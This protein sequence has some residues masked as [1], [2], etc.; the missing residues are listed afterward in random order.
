MNISEYSSMK[1]LDSLFFANIDA[2]PHFGFDGLDRVKAL[3]RLL[4]RHP[5]YSQFQYLISE[6]LQYLIWAAFIT[7][8]SGYSSNERHTEH[9]HTLTQTNSRT[10]TYARTQTALAERCRHCHR[11]I[12]S[13]IRR[14]SVKTKLISLISIGSLSGIISLRICC[15]NILLLNVWRTVN[16]RTDRE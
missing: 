4:S 12:Y 6:F 10:R 16:R 13:S 9:L 14:S 1:L 8:N 15:N 2:L 5:R 11:P 3:L 7:Q